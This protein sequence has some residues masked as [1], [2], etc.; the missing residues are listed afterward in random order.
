MARIKT[1]K[2][3]QTVPV[4]EP[5]LHFYIIIFLLVIQTAFLLYKN[6]GFISEQFRDDPN[7]GYENDQSG[8]GNTAVGKDT[9]S[10]NPSAVRVSILN[11]C[12]E[13]GLASLWKDKLRNMKYDVRETGNASGRYNKT[14][15][16]SR[17]EDMS[18][19]RHLARSIGVKNENV[20]MQI[21]SDLVD[22]DVTVIMGS[23]HNS[24]GN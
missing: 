9:G 20:L 1:R 12:G 21:N 14:V 3:E 18:Y 15:I 23:D 6:Y 7:A 24:L 8:T 17:T 11:G 10:V 22:I 5:V 2:K 4:K 13:P 16:L 19:A